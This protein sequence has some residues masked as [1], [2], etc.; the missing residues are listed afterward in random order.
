VK[1]CEFALSPV[2]T[3]NLFII[4]D[5]AAYEGMKRSSAGGFDMTHCE[6]GKQELQELID[7]FDRFFAESKAEMCRT[8]P[9]DGCFLQQLKAFYFETQPNPGGGD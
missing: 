6:T 4:G 9:D 5:E 8:H 2:P 1:N 7:Q 3:P